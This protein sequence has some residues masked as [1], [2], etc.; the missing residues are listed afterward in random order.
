MK[1]VEVHGGGFERDVGLVEV[2]FEEATETVATNGKTSVLDDIVKEELHDGL[3]GSGS[4]FFPR[5]AATQ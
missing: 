1:G 2:S 5:A 3:F 4:N